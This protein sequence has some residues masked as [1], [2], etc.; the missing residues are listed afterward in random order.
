MSPSPS[1]STV[2]LGESVHQQNSSL[3]FLIKYNPWYDFG[4]EKAII[5]PDILSAGVEKI[6]ILLNAGEV[7]ETNHDVPGSYG[8]AGDDSSDGGIIAMLVK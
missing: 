2:A 7:E 4:S 5:R 6:L 1:W 3:Y 8:D